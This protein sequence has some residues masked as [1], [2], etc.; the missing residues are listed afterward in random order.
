MLKKKTKTVCCWIYL[1]G[2]TSTSCLYCLKVEE[3]CECRREVFSREIFD[4]KSE[5]S[6]GTTTE[7]QLGETTPPVGLRQPFILCSNIFKYFSNSNTNQESQED[8][9]SH[10]FDAKVTIKH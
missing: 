6:L 5:F 1:S 10:S 8:Y 3:L 9:I 7:V 2:F 4:C